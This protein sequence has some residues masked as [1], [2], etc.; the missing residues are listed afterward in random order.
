MVLIGRLG[1]FTLNSSLDDSHDVQL[2]RNRSHGHCD[3]L[4]LN[5]SILKAP[6]ASP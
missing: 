1:N 2:K 5:A 6:F 3:E 4:R